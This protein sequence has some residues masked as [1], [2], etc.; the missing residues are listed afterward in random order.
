MDA[1]IRR[2]P[3]WEAIVAQP[4]SGTRVT[5]V[6]TDAP[7]GAVGRAVSLSARS[8]QSPVDAGLKQS[9]Y[10]D[11]TIVVPYYA[12]EKLYG[13]YNTDPDVQA[14]VDDLC[15]A[16]VG[17]GVTI[18]PVDAA[19]PFG[20]SKAEDVEGHPEGDAE[21]RKRLRD[22]IEAP[23]ENPTEDFTMLSWEILRDC[24]VTGAGYSEF[25]RDVAS[26]FIRY[27]WYASAVD[28]R[29]GENMDVFYQ[30]RG[31]KYKPFRRLGAP[32]VA[33]VQQLKASKD[34]E[35][36]TVDIVLDLRDKIEP[37]E[38][39]IPRPDEYLEAWSGKPL[40]FIETDED[41]VKKETEKPTAR[42]LHEMVQIKFRDPENS[43]YGRPRFLGAVADHLLVQKTTDW[44]IDFFDNNTIP[45]IAVI[46]KGA[47]LQDD[48]LQYVV[49]NLARHAGRENAHKTLVIEV[50]EGT[51]VEFEK[52][53]SERLDEGSFIKLRDQSG[54]RIFAV[55]RVPVSRCYPAK[56]TSA[57]SLQE[58]NRIFLSGVVAPLQRWLAAIFNRL[59]REH[60]GITDWVIGFNT[61]EAE[62]LASRATIWTQLL[63]KGVLSINEVRRELGIRSIPGGDENYVTIPGTGTVVISL[64]P[65]FARRALEGKS[66]SD[67]QPSGGAQTPQKGPMPMLKPSR[68]QRNG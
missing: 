17:N 32:E 46:V 31:R 48:A 14:A 68:G 55:L 64:L 33:I 7:E 53:N 51:D 61:M 37:T 58:A 45:P 30:L 4:A 20:E 13:I 49:Q 23:N 40:S 43:Y 47:E 36:L 66:R 41:K 6:W 26:G 34:G 38:L 16:V 56:A 24:L 21:Q 11:A 62:D 1:K 29:V 2:G 19:N 10:G 65:E 5:E 60:M 39:R 52:L 44:N 27:M 8:E 28:T 42:S 59:F 25:A 63:T 57:Q 35:D 12:P 50:E 15:D 18:K 67:I 54:D 22:F 3:G 9:V